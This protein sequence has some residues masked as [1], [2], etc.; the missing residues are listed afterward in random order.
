MQTYVGLFVGS[1]SM[2]QSL[3]Y[4][5]LTRFAPYPPRYG[6]D[7]TYS[8]RLMENLASCA[9]VEVLCYSDYPTENPRTPRLNWNLVAWRPQP[10]WRS[11]IAGLPNVAAQYRRDAYTERMLELAGEADAVII[12]HLGMGW[13]A[14]ALRRAHAGRSG[15]ARPPL[16]FI[17]IDHNKSLR[18]FVAT[19]VRNPAMRALVAWDAFKASRLED[20]TVELSD[21][22][23]V[24]TE[25]DGGLFRADH[26]SKQYLLVQPGYAGGVVPA[27]CI[28]ADTPERICVLG[29]RGTFHKQIVLQQCL[30]A[31]GRQGAPAT[32][33]DVVGDISGSLRTE[34]QARY[35]GLTFR[36]Y[37]EDVDSYLAT[38]RLGI[39]PDAVGGGFKLRAL[40]YAFNR[41]PMVAVAGALAGMGFTPGENYVEA[42]DLDSMVNEARAMVTDFDR[43]N[44]IQEAAF[45][46]CQGQFDWGQRAAALHAFAQQLS[47]ARQVA[48]HTQLGLTPAHGD[49]S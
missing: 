32:H 48:A 18:T 34:L 40:T 12:D 45:Q 35:P 7:V 38:V 26:P 11:V 20:R 9:P 28:N 44:R 39:L 23:V 21:G 15:G 33:L 8:A 27:R 3:S 14:E 4:L 6:G 5:W 47:R 13:C 16:I 49:A 31:L 19:Q 2:E 46:H 43:L 30:E 1:R 29:G 10:R 17:P 42:P 25:R 24:L 41:V 22:V 37:I 36:G